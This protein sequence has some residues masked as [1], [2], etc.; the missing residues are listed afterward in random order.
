MTEEEL[1]KIPFKCVCCTAWEDEHTMTYSALDGRLG[2]CDHTPI[3]GYGEFGK[4][5][6]HWQIEGKVYRSTK[7]FLEALKD[8]N[9]VRV[10]YKEPEKKESCI[11]V[12]FDNGD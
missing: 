2:F 9:P 8:F 5:R 1:S 3:N 7:K 12:R 6:R 11:F 4:Y 10:A